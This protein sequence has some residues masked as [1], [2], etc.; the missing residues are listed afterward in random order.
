MV[1]KTRGS[2]NPGDFINRCDDNAL[3]EDEGILLGITETSVGEDCTVSSPAESGE[4]GL[5]DG[6]LLGALGDADVMESRED[7]ASSRKLQS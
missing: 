6:L 1:V 5:A 3:G 7:G 2:S 4:M